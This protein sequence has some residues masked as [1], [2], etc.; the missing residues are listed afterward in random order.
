MNEKENE[1][2]N[3]KENKSQNQNENENEFDFDFEIETAAIELCLENNIEPEETFT[4][5]LPDS[6]NNTLSKYFYDDL[7]EIRINQVTLNKLREIDKEFNIP[8]SQPIVFDNLQQGDEPFEKSMNEFKFSDS[9]MS[10]P[11]E[12]DY[13]KR[14]TRRHYDEL[15]N[16]MLRLRQ[17]ELLKIINHKM[18][19]KI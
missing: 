6:L 18:I 10:N 1:T 13:L 14:L 12:S 11:Q 4:F 7:N 16:K 5:N 19:S 17:E 15:V 9:S 8:S 3:E 2:Q